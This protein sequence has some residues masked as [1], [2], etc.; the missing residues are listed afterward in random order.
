MSALDDFM[1]EIHLMEKEFSQVIMCHAT[2]YERL[3]AWKESDPM[4][5]FYEVAASPYMPEDKIFIFK[6]NLLAPPWEQK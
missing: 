3:Q 1:H 2:H 5:R 6:A 4:G